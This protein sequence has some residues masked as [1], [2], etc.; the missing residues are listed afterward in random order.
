MTREIGRAMIAGGF[1]GRIVNIASASVIGSITKGHAVYASS[2]SALLGLARA[3][4]FEFEF[5]EHQ[6]TVNPILTGG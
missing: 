1:G 2:K 5:A 3:S 6:V 4:A